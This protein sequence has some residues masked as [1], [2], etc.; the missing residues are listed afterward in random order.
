[1]RHSCEPFAE[2][3]LF[4]ISSRIWR[5][6]KS[7]STLAYSACFDLNHTQGILRKSP[8][9]RGYH[10]TAISEVLICA[11]Q[12][13]SMPIQYDHLWTSSDTPVIARFCLT[14][15]GDATKYTLLAAFGVESRDRDG[16][17]Q[18]GATMREL[19]QCPHCSAMFEDV[20]M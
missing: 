13:Q 10:V 9:V 15:L 16:N 2:R 17:L 5:S 20:Y 4:V 14:W 12:P 11:P 8:C 1:M 3:S 18:R 6:G 19:Q 7:I